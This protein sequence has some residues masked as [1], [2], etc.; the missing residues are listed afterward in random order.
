MVLKVG[1][2]IS[3][4]GSNLQALIDAAAVSDFPARIAVVV[5][6]KAGAMGLKR[7]EKAKIP[8]HVISHK[9]FKTPEAF[10]DA[11]DEALEAAG[12]ELICLAGFMR[13]LSKAFVN[14]WKGRIINI[15][16]SLLP[17]FKG[18]HV[19]ERVLESGSRVSGCTVHFVRADMDSGPIIIQA[20]VPVMPDDTPDS[21]AE[22]VLAWEHQIY[23]QAVRFIAEKRVRVSGEIVRITGEAAPAPGFMSPA[24]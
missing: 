4:R 19:H 11:L 16:P 18:L 2:L 3:G 13:L 1:V 14:K 6:N 22:R 8:A 15:H 24:G 23:P 12:V 5:S 17:L 7:A 20:A 10:E 21:L 9:S